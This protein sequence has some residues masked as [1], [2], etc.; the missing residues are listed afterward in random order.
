MLILCLQ[1]CRSRSHS[2]VSYCVCST[3]DQGHTLEFGRLKFHVKFTPGH[4]VG[5]VLYTLSGEEFGIADSV[6]SGDL[7]FLGGMGK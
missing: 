6:F 1:H 2:R 3:V 4:T 5:H 7:I